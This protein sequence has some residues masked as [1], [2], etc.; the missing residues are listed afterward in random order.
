M[1]FQDA[2]RQDSRA[3]FLSVP[4]TFKPE[5]SEVTLWPPPKVQPT[6]NPKDEPEPKPKPK[7]EPSS[8]A[9]NTE[10]SFE[11]VLTEESTIVGPMTTKTDSGRT[12]TIPNDEVITVTRHTTIVTDKSP[13]STSNPP[14]PT[15]GAEESSTRQVGNP[16]PASTETPG[17]APNRDSGLPTGGIIGIGIGGAALIAFLVIL[18]VMIKRSRKRRHEQEQTEAESDDQ[19]YGG[20]DRYDEKHFPQ[21]MSAHSTGTQGS[22]DPFAPFGGESQAIDAALVLAPVVALPS[23]YLIHH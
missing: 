10:K 21:H 5:E 19:V 3:V 22:K 8:R 11:A 1:V 2:V 18:A 12:V 4:S 13:R 23:Y 17:Q 9:S 15:A 7:P 16:P 6:A 14:E 20:A